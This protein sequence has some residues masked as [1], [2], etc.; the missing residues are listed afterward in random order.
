[1][2]A[3]LLARDI[4]KLR[5]STFYLLT[6]V[7][8]PQPHRSLQEVPLSVNGFKTEY[9][10]HETLNG[11]PGAQTSSRA[12]Y[13]LYAGGVLKSGCIGL[14]GGQGPWRKDWLG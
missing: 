8:V 13:G 14:A 2:I 10:G 7:S 9:Q 12:G 4:S 3:R 1:M 5:H 11:V 6:L